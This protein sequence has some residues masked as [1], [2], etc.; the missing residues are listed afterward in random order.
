M[1]TLLLVL[2]PLLLFTQNISAQYV[3]MNVPLTKN[4]ISLRNAWAGGMNLPQFSEVDLNNNGVL[5]LVVFDREG[6]IASTFING[7]TANQVDYDYAPE[8]MKH[9][10]QGVENF[11]LFRDYNCDGIEDIFG[12]YSLWGQGLGVAVWQGSYG[13]NDTLQFTLIDSQL[14]YD[15]NLSILLKM[16]VFNTDL[17]AIDDIDG[18]GDLD[19][20]AF[21]LD[22]CFSKNVFW[23]KNTSVENGYGCDSLI[24][25]L[26][27]ECW[28]RFEEVGD[29]VNL[30][31]HIDSCYNNG[32]FVAKMDRPSNT[33]EGR[34]TGRNARHVGTNLTSIDYNGDGVKDMTVGTV[35]YKNTNMVSG[36]SYADTAFL[37]TSQDYSYPVYDTP[38]D[39]YTF[40]STYF[41]DVNNDGK[42]D[43]IAS[44]S[45]TG[46]GESVMDSVA[47]LYQNITNDT[48]M[49][50]NFQQKDFLV[51]EMLDVG[52]RAY[53]SVFDYNADG[54]QDLVIGGYGACQYGGSYKYGLTLLENKGTLTNPS[55]EYVTNNFAALD[56]L[57][58]NGLHPTFGDIDGDG[59]VDMICGAQDGTLIFIDNWAGAGNTA[60]WGKPN[61]NYFNIDVGDASAPCLVD[62]DRDGDLDIVVGHYGGSLH[63]YENSGNINTPIFL[64]VP[65][66]NT[67]GGYSILP[68]GSRNSMPFVHNVNGGFE[69]FI[70]HQYG[71]YIH[72]AV[73]ANDIMGTYDTLSENYNDFY[74]GRYSDIAIFDL[75]NDNKLDYLLGTG[76]GG[77]V[78]MTEANT[79]TTITPIKLEQKV[80]KL[81]PNPAQDQ[82]T[83]SFITPNKGDLHLTVYNALGQSLLHT[84][85]T[86]ASQRYQLD[87]SSMPSGVLFMDVQTDDYHEVVR[88]V[89]R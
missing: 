89:K 69:F 2:L 88:F 79:I 39:I 1:K 4:G 66:T 38:V 76:R 58:L 56:S 74:V 70:G 19:I 7:G 83:I 72:L 78:L 34:S 57:N 82:L 9:L 30:S 87:I 65:V 23:Y 18:D 27:T 63:Y 17:P 68:S 64:S 80:M 22:I 5:D 47:W 10:P 49:V 46:I 67:L 12:M 41:L 51:G 52:H 32:W 43:M 28:G 15:A 60:I 11:M 86:A 25:D 21:T 8:Y 13:P 31:P 36:L 29:S 81:Y 84:T 33:L 42:T 26:E 77:L 3:T 54:L 40:P 85:K 62:L 20:L 53:P 44:P 48:N 35:T 14:K 16:F 73:V 50:F 37:M 24:F 61:L 71:N 6:F 55:F 45:E 75:N 59:D